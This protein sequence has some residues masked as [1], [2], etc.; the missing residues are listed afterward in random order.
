MNA[1][2][3]NSPGLLTKPCILDNLPLL[4]ALNTQPFLAIQFS[5]G[6]LVMLVAAFIF[7][8]LLFFISGAEVALFSLNYKDIS[9]LKKKKHAAARKIVF[10][11]ENP[12]TLL[13]ALTIANSFITIAIII[14]LNQVIEQMVS[15]NN[16]SWVLIMLIK[17]LIIVLI[18]VL[19]GQ[20]LPKVWAS[21]Y[22]LRF[23]YYSSFAVDIT[24]S[25]FRGISKPLI[26]VSDSLEQRFAG[27]EKTRVDGELLDYAIDEL[28]EHEATQEEKKMLKGIRK[29]GNTT[30]KQVMRP[31][32]E[33]SGIPMNISFPELLKKIEELHYSRLPV[34]EHTLDEI[35][36]VIH[37][38]DI[39]PYSSL[40]E[41][42]WQTLIRPTYFVHE[43]KMIEDLLQEFR[44]RHIH[45]A[46]VVDEF[47]GTSGIVT[48][49]DIL[50]EVIGE[51]KDEFD[52]E[53][54][55][56]QHSEDG[57]FAIDGRMMINDMCRLIGLPVDTFDAVRGGSDSV[58][59][60]ILEIN[61][62][63]P[64]QNDVINWNQFDFTIT[65][66]EKNR[67]KKVKLTI[68]PL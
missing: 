25:L 48:L 30:V 63:I 3:G 16:Y 4:N 8:I 18:V 5:N 56:L 41:H 34:Y 12:K 66:V 43:Q 57:S 2:C 24:Y 60:L 10:F 59:G 31:R 35:K 42:D 55:N 50:E 27:K 17:I 64:Q 19:F 13:G 7:L 37:T 67:V 45:F 51:I 15:G 62:E 52:D 46:V 65:E 36:G 14:L 40:Q 23:A 58:G 29:F 1:L 61:E 9:V 6:A 20:V 53:E 47:G 26:R 54:P 11:L 38:K 44:S 28:P 32:L 49:E 22:N 21:H 33:V 39:L 68:R